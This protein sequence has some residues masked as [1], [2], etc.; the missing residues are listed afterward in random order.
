M[1]TKQKVIETISNFPDTF[2]IDELIEK[3]IFLEKVERGMLQ[4][5]NG[6]S[7]SEKE[8]DQEMKKWFK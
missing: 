5:E 7:I 2:S 4:S 1:L 8:L 3:L 6:E